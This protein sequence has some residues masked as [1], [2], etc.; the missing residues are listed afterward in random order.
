MTK[1]YDCISREI[2]YNLLYIN[3]K[4]LTYYVQDY[5]FDIF[6]LIYF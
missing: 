6:R 3:G 1:L 2:I 5:I 4:K